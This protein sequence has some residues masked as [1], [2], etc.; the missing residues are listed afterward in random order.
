MSEVCEWCFDP[1]EPSYY[2]TSCCHDY[3]IEG[4]LA[5]NSIK[6]CL[7]CSKE[8]KKVRHFTKEVRDE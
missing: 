6:Y 8:I 5:D 2:A 7:F 4:D 3:F 1:A